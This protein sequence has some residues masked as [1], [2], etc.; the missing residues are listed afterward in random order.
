M[1]QVIQGPHPSSF[2]LHPFQA[3]RHRNCPRLDPPIGSS[4]S[5][6]SPA[7]PRP[8]R[9]VARRS[10]HRRGIP[11]ART[12]RGRPSGPTTPATFFFGGESDRDDRQRGC[13]CGHD[14]PFLGHA[15]RSAGTVRCE[16]DVAALA[17][18][19]NETAQRGHPSARRRAARRIHAVKS[20]GLRRDVSVARPGAHHRDRP[21]VP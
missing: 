16:H 14:D 6:P 9:P 21:A 5:P 11:P 3:T 15:R 4:P 8:P 2:I 19:T 1:N 18:G 12:A 17:G 20:V 7:T 10:A 13:L